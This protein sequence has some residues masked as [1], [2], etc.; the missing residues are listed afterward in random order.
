MCVYIAL[1]MVVIDDTH[2]NH[3]LISQ[4]VA[5]FLLFILCYNYSVRLESLTHSAMDG[6]SEWDRKRL[7]QSL[8]L[9]NENIL[10]YHQK[11]TEMKKKILRKSK[12][13]NIFILELT[14]I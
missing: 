1:E 7:T 14:S 6:N 10:S 12:K 8:C 5:Q 4:Y 13:K 3:H 9:Q 11:K 2:F